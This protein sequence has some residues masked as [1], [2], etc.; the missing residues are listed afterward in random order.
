MGIKRPKGF[1]RIVQT[2]ISG[3]DQQL[4]LANADQETHTPIEIIKLIHK[5]KE[6]EKESNTYL[7]DSRL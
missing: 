7:W 4:E 3:N 5:I 1:I 6:K 2:T